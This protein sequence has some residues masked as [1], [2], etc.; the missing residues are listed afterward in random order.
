MQTGVK[1]VHL[2]SA[3]LSEDLPELAAVSIAWIGQQILGT[4]PRMTTARWDE[5]HAVGMWRKPSAGRYSPHVSAHG[6]SPRMTPR[7]RERNSTDRALVVSGAPGAPGRA[8]TWCHS[9]DPG[10]KARIVADV[11]RVRPREP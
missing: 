6:T 5:G 2:S 4:S 8:V 11:L 3:G 9:A 7:D 10:A 1:S